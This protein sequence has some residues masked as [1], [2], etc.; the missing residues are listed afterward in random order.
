MSSSEMTPPMDSPST[1]TTT[2]AE[3]PTTPAAPPV[4]LRVPL[5][6]VRRPTPGPGPS[7]IPS[8]SP[9]AGDG[10]VDDPLATSG[11]IRSSEPVTT[12]AV[13]VDK[14]ALKELA[15][16]TVLV[17]SAYVH[18]LLARSDEEREQQL[19]LAEPSDQKQ[20]GDPL[21]SIADRHAAPGV[22]SPDAADLIAAGIGVIAYTAKNAAKA[23][24]IRRGRR[25]LADLDPVTETP[26]GVA[27]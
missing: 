25:R 13:K 20:I 18:A 16:D 22:G 21:A 8:T 19:W 2:T 24:R 1:S 26:A 9:T 6:G 10:G 17:V 7:S 23:W 4:G 3:T 15:R 12:T 27:P 14:S 5:L 11:G